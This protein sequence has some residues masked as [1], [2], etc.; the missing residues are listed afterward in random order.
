MRGR[1]GAA[2][3]SDDVVGDALLEASYDRTVRCTQRFDQEPLEVQRCAL[4]DLGQGD[5]DST[6]GL[7]AGLV[8]GELEPILQ[9][10]F[11]CN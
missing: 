4:T 1:V 9:N 5:E 11:C 6:P 8:H 3:A 2:A 7:Y 10:L